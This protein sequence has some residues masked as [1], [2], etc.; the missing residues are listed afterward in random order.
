MFLLLTACQQSGTS[1]ELQNQGVTFKTAKPAPEDFD[2]WDFIW[3]GPKRSPAA[4]L[5]AEVLQPDGSLYAK[6]SF[7]AY[8]GKS[9]AVH[10]SFSPGFAGGDPKVFY[11]QTIRIRFR[12]DK[13]AVV[14]ALPD[15]KTF[16]FRFFKKDA[17]GDIDWRLPFDKIEAVVTTQ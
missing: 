17:N 3:K 13:G 16:Q 6:Q 9:D 2:A 8:P 1:T 15:I 10:T 5:Q 14:F 12:V 7:I 4:N 11:H